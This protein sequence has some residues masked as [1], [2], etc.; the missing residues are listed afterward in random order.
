MNNEETTTETTTTLPEESSP[1]VTSEPQPTEQSLSEGTLY[2]TDDVYLEL[3]NLQ[4]LQ[5]SYYNDTLSLF[6]FAV[7]VVIGL[8]AGKLFM[9]EIQKW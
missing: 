7:G 2:S 1:M 3:V 9:E 4:N 5:A 8:V 6:I